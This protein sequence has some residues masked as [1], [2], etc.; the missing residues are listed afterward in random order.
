MNGEAAFWVLVNLMAMFYGAFV[1]GLF[2][3]LFLVN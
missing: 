3:G 1:A 2:T